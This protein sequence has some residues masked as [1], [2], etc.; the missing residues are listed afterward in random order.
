MFWPIL[1]SLYC[2]LA[3]WL[4][5]VDKTHPVQKAG[6]EF[7]DY[8]SIKPKLYW[9][10]F[11][12]QLDLSQEFIVLRQPSL[13]IEKKRIVDALIFSFVGV[14]SCLIYIRIVFLPS[15]RILSLTYSLLQIFL[16]VFRVHIA[17][18]DPAGSEIV[19]DDWISSRGSRLF[20]HSSHLFLGSPRTRLTLQD[21]SLDLFCS[22][23][24]VFHCYSLRT[25]FRGHLIC[26]CFE[27]K[28][29]K[30]KSGTTQNKFG[31]VVNLRQSGW[32]AM[33]R[34][35]PGGRRSQLSFR[36]KGGL[37]GAEVQGE[38]TFPNVHPPSPTILQLQGL[39]S[40]CQGQMSPQIFISF[41]PIFF[42]STFFIAIAPIC[43]NIWLIQN[44]Q[45]R[46]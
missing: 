39:P 12:V 15:A 29:T 3:C 18:L 40:H 24:G 25:P 13:R 30:Q 44:R 7:Y 35:N 31:C 43:H 36:E 6:G 9:M 21:S 38:G 1:P 8:L 14:I 37:G 32:N 22:I 42:Y 46:I 19:A 11:V 20:R 23:W 26:R 41:L 2:S 45:I 10:I 33:T 28:Q 4:R 16:F 5:C 27:S 17:H 34:R